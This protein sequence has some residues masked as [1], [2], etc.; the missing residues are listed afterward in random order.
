MP[1]PDYVLGVN[2]DLNANELK[3]A[4]FHKVP[5]TGGIS[6]PFTGQLVLDTSASPN[7][8]L[9]YNGTSWIPWSPSLSPSLFDANTILKAD[10]DDT[11]VALTVGASTLVGRAASGGIAA[12]TATQ[13]K[14]LLAI[15]TADVSGLGSLATKNTVGS[16]EITDGSIVDADISP[17][18]AIALSKL[19]VDPLARANHTGTQLAA[20]IS[21]FNTAVR[22]NR[23]DQ[24]AAPAADLSLNG[25]K[26]TNSAQAVAGTDVPNLTQ[27]TALMQGVR[28]KD[29]VRSASTGNINLA[30]PG[31]TI[32]GVTMVAGDRF[33]AKDQTAGSQNG[34]YV[35]NGAAAAA[36]RSTDADSSAEVL[37]GMTTFVSEGSTN[38]DRTYTLITDAPITLNTTALVFTQSGGAGNMV[39]TAN[40]ITVVGNTIGISPNYT[41]GLVKAYAQDFGDGSSTAITITHN[42][43]TLD[44][45][46]EIYDKGN[47]Y[48]EGYSWHRASTNTI[49][50]HAA[51][52]PL[53]GSKRVIVQAK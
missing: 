52:A 6:T 26:I 49:I 5:G 34:I 23:L 8:P 48:T 28:T 44:V 50:I 41:A 51:T 13:A 9:Y 53:T 31:A 7:V 33:L 18:A 16:A 45:Q 2:L 11:P 40:E 46:V 39:G 42:L 35:W 32:D 14:T 10:A 43:N 20:T 24:M 17:S 36:T 38:V 19:A 12:L 21:D 47:G 30:A 22:T 1:A 29:Y 25:F 27:V 15:S 3:Q 4:T 37:P